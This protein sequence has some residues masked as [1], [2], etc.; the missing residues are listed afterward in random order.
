MLYRPFRITGQGVLTNG[1][2]KQL[3]CVAE[4]KPN[5]R[6]PVRGEGRRVLAKVIGAIPEASRS[7]RG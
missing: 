1:E 2:V 4:G 7:M 3:N 6:S 5:G